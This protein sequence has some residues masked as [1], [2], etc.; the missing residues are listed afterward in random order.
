MIKLDLLYKFFFGTKW[1][2]T[3]ANASRARLNSLTSLLLSN[4]SVPGYC[5][6]Y[7]TACATACG[8]LS[9]M[10]SCSIPS[11]PLLIGCSTKLLLVASITNTEPAAINRHSTLWCLL[12]CN[13]KFQHEAWQTSKPVLQTE[14]NTYPQNLRH[15]F[16]KVEIFLPYLASPNWCFNQKAKHTWTLSYF[17]ACV[18][19]ATRLLI[20][21][22]YILDWRAFHVVTMYK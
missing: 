3:A 8:F 18:V 5:T 15:S 2:M 4:R 16:Q 13:D 10:S 21:S 9:A 17:L 1:K 20:L 7:A 22:W 14:F 12:A 11:T 19:I 6:I